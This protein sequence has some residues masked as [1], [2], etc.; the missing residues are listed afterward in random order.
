[1]Q[2]Q[3]QRNEQLR[4]AEDAPWCQAWSLLVQR[5][6][7]RQHGHILYTT[8]AKAKPPTPPAVSPAVS[9]FNDRQDPDRAGD[10]EGVAATL[11]LALPAPGTQIAIASTAASAPSASSMPHDPGAASSGS[12]P[13]AT[14]APAQQIIEW[15]LPCAVKQLGPD[16][17]KIP[18]MPTRPVPI[19]L[20]FH[21][22]DPPGRRD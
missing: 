3:I 7:P 19:P 10:G 17:H 14:A 5:P 9:A 6:Q 11:D 1:M 16:K 4:Q 22:R 13:P 15:R 18:P 2:E 20:V 12:A 8:T 21:A